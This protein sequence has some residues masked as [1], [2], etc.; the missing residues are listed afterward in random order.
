V[1]AGGSNLRVGISIADAGAA[2]VWLA[3][4]S[5]LVGAE[6]VADLVRYRVGPSVGAHTGPGTAGAMWYPT[7][8]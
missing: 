6:E 5:R 3:L 4:E 1:L 7:V 2:P 8:F